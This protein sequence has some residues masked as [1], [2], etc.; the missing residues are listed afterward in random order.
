MTAANSR[1]GGSVAT[2]TADSSDRDF[3]RKVLAAGL[4]RRYDHD[5]VSLSA[6]N[7]ETGRGATYIRD[8]L[9]EH[10][11]LR[12]NNGFQDRRP[13]RH[14]IPT[15]LHIGYLKLPG[16]HLDDDVRETVLAAIAK[17]GH[18][19]VSLPTERDDSPA[20]PAHLPVLTAL[21]VELTRAWRSKPHNLFGAAADAE[22]DSAQ[23][24]IR[25]YTVD[26]GI[27][28][29]IWDVDRQVPPDNPLGQ[30]PNVLVAGSPAPPGRG[31][32]LA[33]PIADRALDRADLRGLCQRPRQGLLYAG[34]RHDQDDHLFTSVVAAAAAG[35]PHHIV[36]SWPNTTAWPRLNFTG[37]VSRGEQGLAYATSLAC[38]MLPAPGQTVLGHR[39]SDLALAVI[40]GCL[41][42]IHVSVSDA[43]DHVPEELIVA[44]AAQLDAVYR[45]LD[46][47]AG[48]RYHRD[49]LTACWQYR[50]RHRAS[51]TVPRLLDALQLL[52]RRAGDPDAR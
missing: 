7:A 22:P 6:I 49:L 15:R 26:R 12:R 1:R 30:L 18:D 34:N 48:S 21:V 8:L 5:G 40:N 35:L 29:L 3:A 45:R 16:S 25:H 42:L 4:L 32:E 2:A 24:M 10:T 47:L 20:R 23:S 11:T 13:R 28:T 37:P 14:P 27:A 43:D 31:L 39:A 50:Q 19:V 17:A 44:D 41:P 9:L 51:D 52:A 33:V 46:R 36:G 38:L